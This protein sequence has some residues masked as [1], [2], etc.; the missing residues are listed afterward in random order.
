MK[1]QTRLSLYS[2]TVFGSIFLILS[3][4]IYFSYGKY[5]RNTAYN[6]LRKTASITAIFY[7]EEDELNKEDFARVREQFNDFVTNSDYQIYNESDGIDYG[8]R[9]MS[10]PHSVLQTIR[11]ERSLRFSEERFYCYGIYYEDNQGNF[12]VI[13]RERKSAV[14]GQLRMLIY[15]LLLSFLAG[16]TAIVFLNRLIANIAYKPFRRAIREVN[17]ISTRNLD[18]QIELPEAKDELRDLI[19]TFNTLLERIAE[20]VTIQK[21]FIRYVSHEFKT[22]LA[23]MLGN[24]EILEMKERQPA[25]YRETATKLIREVYHLEEILNTLSVVSDLK[26]ED[27]VNSRFRLDELL[28]EII[29][30]TGERYPN[31]KV[32]VT[33]EVDPAHEESLWISQNQTQLLMALF[34]LI[35]N[36]AKYSDGK[37]IGIRVYEEKTRLCL[38]I[39]DNGIGIPETELIHISKPLYRADNTAD[40]GGSGIGLSIALRILQRNHLEYT[41]ESAIGL[42]TVIKIRF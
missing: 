32:T 12:V 27:G 38:E 34:N 39:R 8:S 2:S 16:M 30:K 37:P 7:L 33:T 6:A 20:M 4:F 14:T 42:G 24:L 3:A 5:A 19:A 23:A 17:N 15:I 36:A 40:I 31:V 22:P 35:E 13:A 29:G 25:E 28:W 18:V 26:K 21:N 1:I 11:K 9:K 10:V 41:I